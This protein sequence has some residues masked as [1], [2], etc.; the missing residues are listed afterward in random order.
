MSERYVIPILGVRV[1]H[2]FKCVAN[3]SAAHSFLSAAL[4]KC[5]QGFPC[6]QMLRDALQ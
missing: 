3:Q 6:L 4:E 1:R 5:K 2:N